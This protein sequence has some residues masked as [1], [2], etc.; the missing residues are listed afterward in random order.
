VEDMSMLFIVGT[1][2]MGIA[3]ILNV[4]IWIHTNKKCYWIVGVKGTQPSILGA[5]NRKQYGIEIQRVRDQKLFE[6][7]I[8]LY[9]ICSNRDKIASEMRTMYYE[10]SPLRIAIENQHKENTHEIN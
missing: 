4:A 5:F 10:S 8:V 1:S 9:R 3:I 6:H 2:L 7:Y